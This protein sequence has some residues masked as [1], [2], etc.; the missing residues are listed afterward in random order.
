MNATRR[1]DLAHLGPEALT[2]LANAGLVKRA[3]R[4]REA[5]YVPELELEDDDTL[6]ATFSDG[7]VTRWPK[8]KPI[9]QVVCTCVATSICRHRL[10]AALRFQELLALNGQAPDPENA[11]NTAP[12]EPGTAAPPTPLPPAA[13]PSPGQATD[14]ALAALVPPVLLARAEQQRQQGVL[15]HVHRRAAPGTAGEPCD[16]ARLPAATVRYWAGAAIE[17]ARCDCVQ[18]SACEHVA[19]GVWAFREADAR[20]PGAPTLPVQLGSAD[21][22]V[23]LPVAPYHAVLAALLRHGVLQGPATCAQAISVALSHA[24][25]AGA[26]WLVHTLTDLEQWLAAYAARS[27]RYQAEDGFD[28]ATELVLRLALGA[29]PGQAKA[30]LGI[31]QPHEVPLDRLRLMCLGARTERDGPQRRTRLVMADL[32]TGSRMALLH[33][34]QVPQPESSAPLAGAPALPAAPVPDEAAVRAAERVAP[35]VKL[36]QLATGQLLCSQ[37]RRRADGRVLLAKARGAQ[38]SLLPQ[39]GDWSQLPAPLRYS[40]VADLRQAR[41]AEPHPIASPRHAAGRFVVFSPARIEHAFYDPNQQVLQL[42]ALDAEGEPLLV[43]RAHAAHTPHALAALALA[44]SGQHGPLRHVGGVLDWLGATPVLHAW[45]CAADR[46]WALDFALADPPAAAALAAL[47]LGHADDTQSTAPPEQWLLQLRALCAAVLHHGTDALPRHWPADAQQCARA[48]HDAGFQ[49][50]GAAL[51]D[52]ANALREA[53][54]RG[55]SDAPQTTALAERFAR[56]ITLR[57]LHVDALG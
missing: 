44:L 41:A 33:D 14:A 34:W 7:V 31:G 9:T 1:P 4:E 55:L 30:V 32:D 53:A 6:V 50:L 35:G 37:A 11:S 27:A 40:R 28:L 19:L 2:Q 48:L 5:G 45:S 52:T 47:P 57:Q 25:A 26:E 12:A 20:L 24:T 15:I 8:G 29:Q 17:A 16:T 38:N 13:P 39:S 46:L 23:R 43:R 22:A 54:T 10:I 56:L 51:T 18:Q 21:A 36:Q 49:A 3:L 42:L